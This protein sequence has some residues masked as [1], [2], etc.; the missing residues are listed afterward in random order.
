[1]LDIFI[2]KLKG[3]DLAHEK[4]RDFRNVVI[5]QISIIVAALLL[6]DA[7]EMAGVENSYVIRDCIFLL[8]GGVYVL[9]MW[10]MLRN[11]TQNKVIIYALFIIMIG[12]YILTLF[13]VNPIFPLYDT[14]KEQQPYLFFIHMVLFIIEITVM[15]FGILDLFTGNKMSEE[16]LWGSTCIFLMIAISFGSLY[17][18]INIAN[19]GAMGTPLRM[20]LESY[21]ACISH[22]L[23]VV[24]AQDTPFPNAIS[25]IKGISIIESVWANL[26]IVLLVGRLLGQ[27][28]A[29]KK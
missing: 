15:Y 8:L 13:I 20:G 4:K 22:S 2:Q 29:E 3:E 27:P 24:G 10:D 17:D 26:F 6:K 25:V 16:K 1:M 5:L 28:D 23:T 14:E 12:T 9:V 11:F 18:L 21:T 7:F 19:P